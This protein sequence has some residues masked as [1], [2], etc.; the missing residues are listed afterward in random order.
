MQSSFYVSLSSQIA[1]EKR[2][3]AVA[4]N[5]A[6]SG[7]IG[8]RGNGSDF[9]TVLS[10]TGTTP[11][12]YVSLA[13]DYVSRAQ[14]EM[15]KTGNP[16]DVAVA[17]EGWLAIQTPSGTAYTRDGRLKLLET[18]ELQTILGYPVL[19][20]GGSPITLDPQG[21]TPT[22][23]PDGMIS[24]GGTQAGALGLFELD[25]DAVLTRAENSSVIP[26]KPANPVLD[27]ASNGVIQGSLESANV[28]PMLEMSKLIMISHAFENVS[29]V[30]DMMDSSQRNAVKTLGSG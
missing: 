16:L 23:F 24:Q 29:A 20:A 17:G 21:G 11:T 25:Q 8:Y 28:N 1:L 6:N 10:K 9:E 12:A 30:N 27:F 7:T 26:S 2:I 4:T 15:T 22:I 19:D 18:G 5:I 13:S 14:G 3:T